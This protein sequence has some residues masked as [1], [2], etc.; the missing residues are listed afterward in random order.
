MKCL[1]CGEKITLTDPH[2]AV[3]VKKVEGGKIVG[4]EAWRPLPC[5]RWLLSGCCCEP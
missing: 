5:G 4:R 3:Y 2:G 1:Y